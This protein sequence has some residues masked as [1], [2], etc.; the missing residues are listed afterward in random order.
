[1]KALLA[2]TVGLMGACLL[3][4][5]M[6]GIERG[7]KPVQ[8]AG[9]A[10]LVLSTDCPVAMKY[11]PR[12]N[13]LYEKYASRGIE[14]KAIFPNDLETK[15]G[16]EQYRT[17][18]SYVF[19]C[20]LDLGAER[21]KKEGVTV[22]PAILI[23]DASGKKV[24]EGAIDDSK[25]LALV[26]KKYAEDALD[27][28]LEGKK[29]SVGKTDCF[30]CVL[31]PSTSP[32][33]E[34][35][36]TFAEHVAQILYDHCVDCHR[37][38]EVAPFSLLDYESARKWAPMIERVTASR[39]MPPWKAVRGH[40]DFR[41]ENV[42]T[43]TEIETLR[44][45][46]QA[47]APRGKADKEPVPPIASSEWPLGQPDL[48]LQPSK[49]Y[50]LAA[51]GDDVYRHY[52]LKSNFKE[53]RY[54]KAMAVKPGN[55]RVVHHVIAF[56]DE[57]G[58]SHRRDGQD[59]QPGYDTAGGGPGFA[60]DGS[61]GGWAPGLRAQKTPP[62]VAFELKPGATVVLQVHYHKSGKP[63]TD[64]T[65]IGLYFAKEPVEKIMNLA[66][67][68]NPLFR[69]P[70]GAE[71]HKVSL[72]VPIPADAT[73]YSVMPHMH[74]LGKSMKADVLFADGTTRP[75]IFVDDWDFNWQMNYMFKEPIKI[76][77]GSKVR[78][79]AVYDNSLKNRFNP[80]NPPK[81]VTW[82]EQTTD[83]MF[84]LVAAYTL[85]GAR[86]ARMTRMGFGRGG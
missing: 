3:I 17:E 26:R 11:T 5:G 69:I 44:R 60:P 82:G 49:A 42:L 29:P 79:E 52:V 18:R 28:V 78:V 34:K 50:N 40:G 23:F 25:E 57:S 37:P 38:N 77:A 64:Q 45:W 71:N 53:P 75:L 30:G 6:A 51:E 84:L 10:L 47:G 73:V 22:V 67:I 33:S 15:K 21:A 19:P 1:M 41:D 83:E 68:A 7:G 66:W 36:V 32:P 81:A 2:F 9:T 65:R 48:V 4:A 20:E 27:A 55:P 59:G 16:I 61:F 24:Y 35:T 39:R 70:P 31:M 86:A 8:K 76:P 72:T 43:E 85:D 14:F 80:N 13:A 56:L 62:G 46:S 54:V 74:L 12:I 63:E 58:A